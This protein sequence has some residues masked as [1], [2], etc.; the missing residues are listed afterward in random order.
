MARLTARILRL[1]RFLPTGIEASCGRLAMRNLR[2]E[3][4]S[5]PA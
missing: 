3:L 5:W 4:L 2:R 1:E